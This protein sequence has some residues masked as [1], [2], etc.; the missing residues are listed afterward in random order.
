V[1]NVRYGSHTASDSFPLESPE[2]KLAL[3]NDA[4]VLFVSSS[5]DVTMTSFASH[6]ILKP[7]MYLASSILL[8][9]NLDNFSIL[10]ENAAEDAQLDPLLQRLQGGWE[11]AVGPRGRLLSGGER[12]RVCLAR[13]LYREELNG[14]IL[15]MDEVTASL[16]AKTE[17]LVTNAV[18]NRVKK[19]ATA[20]LIAHRLSS[21]QHC[22]QVLVM[23]DGEIIER[24]T[25][26][27]LIKRTGW[28]A[29]SWKLQSETR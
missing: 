2:A 29:E 21:V 5:L 9:L 28:Y 19:G 7:I 17:A 4:S 8:N 14:G 20:V 22:D 18:I 27:Q 3:G 10:S 24:G 25:H 26:A 6:P 13:A 16:D 15:L 1:D 12:Q 11:G 23:K